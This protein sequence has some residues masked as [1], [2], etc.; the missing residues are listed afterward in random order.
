MPAGL[1]ECLRAPVDTEFFQR[2]IDDRVVYAMLPELGADAQ[3]AVSLAGA[4][5]REGAGK[6]CVA[7][8]PRIAQSRQRGFDRPAGETTLFQFAHELERTVLTPCEQPEAGR[9]GLL[10]FILRR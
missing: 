2:L 10:R 1:R 4:M 7:Q 9:V 6:T 8:I 3:I 5:P